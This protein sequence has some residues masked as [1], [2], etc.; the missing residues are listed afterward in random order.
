MSSLCER[1]LDHE[2]TGP[3]DGP[4]SPASGD[5]QYPAGSSGQEQ[6]RHGPSAASDAE[7][8]RLANGAHPAG[9]PHP[10]RTN[11]SENERYWGGETNVV[12]TRSYVDAINDQGQMESSHTLYGRTGQPVS[13]DRSQENSVYSLHPA[14]FRGIET[15]DDPRCLGPLTNFQAGHHQPSDLST[16]D[17]DVDAAVS[18]EQVRRQRNA[19]ER[20]HYQSSDVRQDRREYLAETYV[21]NGVEYQYARSQINRRR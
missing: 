21:E 18:R 8:R 13:T 16:F 19:S 4:I 3:S 10:I 17:Y 12:L 2:L 14:P 9:F 6:S 1:N 7:A 20:A 11:R 15:L 5:S